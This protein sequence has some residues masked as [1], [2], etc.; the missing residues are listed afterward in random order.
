MHNIRPVMSVS[1]ISAVVIGA[2]V[3][4]VNKPLAGFGKTLIVF[5]GVPGS[6]TA[7]VQESM[8]TTLILWVATTSPHTFD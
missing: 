8:L 1:V 3:V 4:T 7:V 2:I 6:S 5:S